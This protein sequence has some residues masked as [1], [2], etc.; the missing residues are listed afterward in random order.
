M[1]VKSFCNLERSSLLYGLG[2]LDGWTTF[3]IVGHVFWLYPGHL[4]HQLYPH[5][6]NMSNTGWSLWHRDS[7]TGSFFLGGM[8][9][10]CGSRE[11]QTITFLFHIG[12]GSEA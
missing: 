5:G 4:L 1:R 10:H 12:V 11:K 7:W 8:Y 2:V 6:C 3:L 9:S